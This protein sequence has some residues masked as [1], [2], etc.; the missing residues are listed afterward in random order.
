MKKYIF[1]SFLLLAVFVSP[2]LVQAQTGLTSTQIQSILSLLASFGAD[3]ATISNV[4][5]ALLGT[6]TTGSSFCYNFDNDITVGS[7][8]SVVSALNQALSSSGID[9][10]G[11]TSI[12]TE[13]NAGDVVSFQARYGIRQT[14]YVGPITRAKLNALYGCPNQ[15]PTTT[16]TLIPSDT[17]VNFNVVQGSSNPSPYGLHLTNGSSA[18]VNFTLNVP[19]Q[20]S[21]YNTGYNTQTM[22]LSPGGV[23]GVGISVDATKV[24]PGTYTANLIVT[25]NFANSPITIPVTLTVTPASSTAPIITT[26]SLPGGTVG[27]SYSASVAGNVG[28]NWTVTGLPDGLKSVTMMSAM[29]VICVLGQTCSTPPSPVSIVGTPTT[30]GSYTVTVTLT[31][32]TQTVSKQFSLIINPSVTI[33][34]QNFP[35]PSFCPGG[36]ADITVTGTDSKGCSIYA[37]KSTVAPTITTAS[38]SNGTVG[39]SYSASIAGSGGTGD[40]TW[41]V[42]GL[43]AGLNSISPSIACFAAPCVN[44]LPVTIA[45]T[46]TTSGTYT[47]TVTLTAGKQVVSK[48]FSLVISNQAYP[49]PF[50]AQPPMPTCSDGMACAQVMPSPKTY[51]S[52]DAFNSDKATYLYAGACASPT[53]ACSNGATNAPTCN[54]FAP[55]VN[56]LTNPPACTI[57][58][59]LY[60]GLQTFD[61]QSACQTALPSTTSAPT[62]TTTSL[63]N[64]IIG[65]SYNAPLAGLGGG[66]WSATGLPAG[67]GMSGISSMSTC[68]G[69]TPTSP[70][71]SCPTSTSIVGTPTTAGTYTVTVTLGGTSKQ[72]SLVIL[73]GALLLG[74]GTNQTASALD[75]LNSA[76][77]SATNSSVPSFS[78]V[79]NNDLQIGSPYSADVTA[80]QEALTKDGVYYGEITGG[81]Y[82]QTF[83]AVQAFQQKYGIESTGFVGSITRAKLNAL[84]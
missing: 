79:W 57:N 58:G 32:G 81:F 42:S 68:S 23:T 10:T 84:Y 24:S 15:P 40:Y 46:P 65:A 78:Y 76:T 8:G 77:G 67:L 11:N 75:A 1:G 5:A 16:G 3:S 41:S 44:Q 45:G 49:L 80:L 9:T 70:P 28:G 36:T 61:S 26:A 62:I 13:D 30:A 48:Q 60:L 73:P 66:T 56:G 25:G 31:A 47:V 6:P 82:S 50:C 74:N 64:G 69:P 4:N 54:I 43:P 71:V 19:N 29:N 83:A 33:S 27:I 2:V 55:C 18:A 17:F 63:P 34:C 20:P 39:T 59:C 21:W 7:R 37:C 22:T 35:P 72:F 53:V 12:F 38:L 14:G 52:N 51:T